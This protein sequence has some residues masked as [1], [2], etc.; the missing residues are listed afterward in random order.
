MPIDLSALPR[1]ALLTGALALPFLAREAFAAPRALTF[2]VFRNGTK[3][4]EHHVSFAADETTLTAT[5]DAVMTVKIGPVPVFKYRHHA[6]EKRV[7]GAFASLVTATDSNGKAERVS[8]E[9]TGGAIR[10]SCPSGA[11]TAPAAANPITHWNPQIFSGPLFNPQNGKLLKV[12]TRKVEPN[13]WAIRGETEIDD[14][15]DA[16]GA[17][18]ALKGKLDDGSAVEYRRV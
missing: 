6:V 13:H 18:L 9:M 5:T 2:A 17:W 14:F 7:G 11:L 1:R 10:I 12:T 4:G 3:I 15:Y 8:A 16:G